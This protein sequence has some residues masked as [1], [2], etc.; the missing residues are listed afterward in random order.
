MIRHINLFMC[1]LDE[2]GEKIND[3]GLILITK[4]QTS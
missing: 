4:N 1:N 3:L 2:N